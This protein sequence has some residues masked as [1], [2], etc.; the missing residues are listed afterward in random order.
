[1]EEGFSGN[2]LKDVNLQFI[3][4]VT[5]HRYLGWICAPTLVKKNSESF[6]TVHEQASTFHFGKEGYSFSE[7]EKEVI[8]LFERFSD[9]HLCKIFSSARNVTDFYAQLT[10]ERFE[11]RIRPYIE[12][13]IHGMLQLAIKNDM[14]VYHRKPNYNN[15]YDEDKLSIESKNAHA[16]FSFDK[17]DE[18][19][20]YALSIKS[21]SFDINL[22]RKTIIVL[23]NSPCHVIIGSRLFCFYDID[24]KKLQ[25]F[26]KKPHINI[27]KSSVD[28]YLET[29]VLNAIK[30]N[31]VVAKG[32]EI[33]D[34]LP[35]HISVLILQED[36]HGNPALSLQFKYGNRYFTK[37][38]TSATDVSFTKNGDDYVFERF[39]RE[40]DW[41]EQQ[42][43]RLLGLGFKNFSGS[44][45]ILPEMADTAQNNLYMLV[46][47]LNKN[48]K[49]LI[50]AGFLLEQK[51][52][53]QIYYTGNI[54]FNVVM[55]DNPDWFELKGKVQIGDFLIPFIRFK[56]NI[57]TGT[58][59][60]V[61]PN[62]EVA[63]LPRDWFTRYQEIFKFAKEKDEAL[64]LDKMHFNLLQ[65]RDLK[66]VDREA[67][68]D[69]YLHRPEQ[70]IKLPEG[71]NAKLRHYQ[72]EGFSWLMHLRK[73]NF[74]GILA[75][76]MGLGKTIQTLTLLQ[77]IYEDNN[78]I[79]S[80]TNPLKTDTPVVDVTDDLRTIAPTEEAAEQTVPASLI[81]MPKSLL[82]NWE[83]EIRKFCPNL[84]VYRYSGN[85]RIRSL[86]IWKIFRH[87]NIVITSYGLVRNDLAYLQSY[88]FHYIILDE[89][90]FIKNPSSKLY[91]SV[92][93]LN[94]EHQIALTG[95]PIENSLQDLWAQFNF[96]NKGLLGS[97]NY[98]R[99]HFV[100]PITK[101]K[102]EKKEER[103]QKI[104][105]PFILRRTKQEVAKDLPPL[106]E[107]ILYCAM[108]DHQKERYKK[109]RSSIRNSILENIDTA[110]ID[111]TR[112]KALQGLMRLRLLANHPVLADKDYPFESGKFDRIIRNLSNLKAE[113][114]KVLI[115]SSFV[116]HLQ[117]I[118]KHFIKENWKYS[119]LTGESRKR[120]EII[121]EFQKD[122][123]NLFF[124]ISLKAG[125]VGL[126]LT[127]AD[128]VFIIDPW[129]NPAAEMQ[130]INRAHRIGQNKKVMVYRFITSKSIEEKITL[131]QQ[132]K[133]Q[134][135]S[136]YI[137]SNNPF[138]NLTEDELKELFQ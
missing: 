127:E 118:E 116:K 105:Q 96:I 44:L 6:I 77:K 107:Q 27:P 46:E 66:P 92:T 41:E 51:S 103:L 13:Q 102:D 91:Q 12:E 111:K 7:P 123:D 52:K 2:E 68:E 38:S 23:S 134:L 128:Y 50:E 138:Q 101:L 31:M 33:S 100:N 15:L 129:W 104:I 8:R 28:K 37:S 60:Y 20:K 82:H 78:F 11:E 53:E 90:H 86:D 114:H 73:N 54:L 21:Q 71:I 47:W 18:G 70:N 16:V 98:F 95:T 5:E 39:S 121:E 22:L 3:I 32:F 135:A 17:H 48:E 63:I 133:S 113:K 67:L 79:D 57:L 87:Y 110:G 89:S 85:R 56:K 25:P 64:Q 42:E 125:G 61:L 84:M 93:E 69:L 59:E 124:L 30:N 45:Y 122:E 106:S 119:M 35:E 34:Y 58:R 72:T 62:G 131:L 24:A 120:G 117:L 83:N 10:L 108:T 81:V 88:K 97:R 112:L 136:T 74:G 1:M 19:L 99:Q 137:N 36:L 29:F 80:N 132:K 14:H 55:E 43:Q 126:N 115:F 40:V 4:T 26:T 109:E 49:K 65:N 9:Q 76:D 94:G 130:A 75:D